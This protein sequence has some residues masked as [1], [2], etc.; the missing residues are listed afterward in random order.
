MK[1][2]HP[3]NKI[4]KCFKNSSI[5]QKQYD[6]IEVIDSN[7]LPELTTTYEAHEA[8]S[9]EDLEHEI[10]DIRKET[11]RLDVLT[12]VNLDDFYFFVGNGDQED[13]SDKASEIEQNSKDSENSNITRL[14]LN[15]V[16]SKVKKFECSE[17]LKTFRQRSHLTVHQRTHT[18][19][20]PFEC[21]ICSKRFYQSIHL[22]AHESI[23]TGQKLFEC[24]KV[25]HNCKTI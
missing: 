9:G 21:R 22:K 25:L 11:I 1:Y 14:E 3:K 19:E 16:D 18:G 17:C 12:D 8:I 6:F 20:K 13:V 10:F 15:T 7:G 23:H 5:V 24:E 4:V 2:G